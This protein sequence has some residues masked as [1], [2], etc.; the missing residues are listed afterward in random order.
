MRLAVADKPRQVVACCRDYS[1]AFEEF[2][3]CN[4]VVVDEG[5]ERLL[6]FLHLN[7]LTATFLNL[8]ESLYFIYS[9]P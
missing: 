8:F 4:I 6:V 5:E 7:L 2:L 1:L 3:W 9:Y